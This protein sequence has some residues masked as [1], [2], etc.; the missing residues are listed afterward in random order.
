LLRG[1]LAVLAAFEDV[2]LRLI[3]ES[4]S[5]PPRV[6]SIVHAI[7]ASLSYRFYAAAKPLMAKGRIKRLDQPAF[8]NTWMSL[9]HYRIAN[10]DLFSDQTPILS[11]DGDELVRLFL[12]L[13]H[14]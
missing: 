2:Y 9:V 6:R 13:V 1:H 14:T 11:R 4:Q 3:S 7:N 12:R 8:F 5:L 10:R